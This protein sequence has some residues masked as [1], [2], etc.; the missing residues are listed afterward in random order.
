MDMMRAEKV[1]WRREA[2][3]NAPDDESPGVENEPCPASEDPL[4]CYVRDLAR[5]P[6]LKA[7]EEKE[8]ASEIRECQQNL[9]RLLLKLPI[10]MEEIKRLRRRVRTDGEDRASPLEHPSVLIEQILLELRNREAPFVKVKGMREMLDQ[11]HRLE[12]RLRCAS[13]R[14]VKSNLRLVLNISKNYHNRGLSLLDLIQE[15]NMG[16][17]KAVG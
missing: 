16:L 1:L 13:D 9:V 14:M 3:P 15:G 8:L 12:S 10:S 5:Y 7:E 4:L 11:I 2:S 17:M 6:L